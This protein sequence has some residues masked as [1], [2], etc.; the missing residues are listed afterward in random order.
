MNKLWN[1]LLLLLS[2]HADD[3]PEPEEPEEEPE[4]PEEPE[5]PEEEEEE[6]IEEV[7]AKPM[8]RAQKE[9]VGLRERA[10]K[11]E[12]QHRKAQDELAEA[13]RSPAKHAQPTNDQLLW[14]AEE[15]SLQD[16]GLESWQRYAIEGRREAREARN[17]GQQ[18]IREARDLSD[19]AAFDRIAQSKPKTVALYKEKVESLLKEVR[20]KGNDVPREK[21][22]ALL[23]GEAILAGDPKKKASSTKT[24]SVKRG[25]T[26]GVR[27]DTSSKSGRLSD[28]AKR[29]KRLENVRI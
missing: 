28:E 9:I 7:V 3:E 1:L 25:T 17:V 23:I 29:D 5:E 2:P 10:Q 6:E 20:S 24:G 8:S 15:K 13:R 26:P 19:K 12:D 22:L 21:L 27:S 18:A 11:A 4:D 16:P 14:E